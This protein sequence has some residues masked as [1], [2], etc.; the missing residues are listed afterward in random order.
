MDKNKETGKRLG[1]NGL[2]VVAALLVLYGISCTVVKSWQ[3]YTDEFSGTLEL[4]G[5][6]LLISAIWLALYWFLDRVQHES[7]K[8]TVLTFSLG[9]VAYISSKTVL[10]WFIGSNISV[11]MENIGLPVLS[12]FI[13]FVF[14]AIRFQS[15][16]ELVDSFIYGGFTGVGIAFAAC[17]TEFLHYTSLDG[18]FVIISLITKIAVHAAICS[19]AG[20]MIHQA[21]LKKKTVKIIISLIAMAVLFALDYIVE[22][23]MMSDLSFA[24]IKI[25][26]VLIA[27][28]FALVLLAVVVILVG[29]TLKKDLNGESSLELPASSAPAIL[30]CILAVLFVGFALCV[31]YNTY[32]TSE[33]VSSNQKWSFSLPQDWSEVQEKTNDSIF[34][35]DIPTGNVFYKN[36]T[37]SINLYLFYDSK[38]ELENPVPLSSENGWDIS[39]QYNQFIARDSYSNPFI[40]YQTTYS[41]KKGDE[42]VLIDVFSD[43]KRD[44]EAERAVRILI[45]TLEAKND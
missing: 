2:A 41:I 1:L 6:S 25:L 31:R 35:F 27:A 8:M 29:V 7:L 24:G 11:F 22:Q 34:D 5:S 4:C 32:K 12:F 3:I 39:L 14:F 33:F 15:F 16:D 38:E 21:L 9:S 19:L 37:G 20:F 43:T 42:S 36:E 18:Q 30:T 45:R 44:S 23:I 28:V 26:P 13:V 17:M 10:D 40:M